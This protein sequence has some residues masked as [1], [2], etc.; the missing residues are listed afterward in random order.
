MRVGVYIDGYNL[1]YGGRAW[2]GRGQPGW[3]WLDVRQMVD[4]VIARESGWAA[5]SV[6]RVVYCTARI[7]A[8]TNPT[9]QTDQDTYLKALR[10]SVASHL[11]IDA[12]KSA[13]DAAVI[14]SNDSD[15]RFPIEEARKLV[16]VGVINP[17]NKYLAGDLRGRPGDGVGHHWWY[18]LRPADFTGAQFPAQVGKYSRPTG[19]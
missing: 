2:C 16:P 6:H 13:V 11:L 1:Y 5:A 15:L 18:Q 17:T 9:G 10:T 7:D 8:R 3:R 14:V 4:G 12:L 19:W